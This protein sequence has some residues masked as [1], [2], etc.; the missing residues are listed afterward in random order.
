MQPHVFATMLQHK[1]GSRLVRLEQKRRIKVQ[2]KP[3]KTTPARILIS[4]DGAF[5]TQ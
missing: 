5:I 2:K 1:L 4:H 3:H